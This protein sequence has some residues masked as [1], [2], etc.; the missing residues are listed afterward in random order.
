MH[1]LNWG[2]LPAEFCKECHFLHAALKNAKFHR[3]TERNTLWK[4]KIRTKN[5]TAGQ[6]ILYTY[7]VVVF[8][9]SIVSVY[10]SFLIL[11]WLNMVS[12]RSQHSKV[13]FANIFESFCG[14]FVVVCSHQKCV[15]FLGAHVLGNHMAEFTPFQ[16]KRGRSDIQHFRVYFTM[17]IVSLL[18]LI[19]TDRC[20]EI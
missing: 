8:L 4:W 11:N 9:T 13:A 3:N 5:S 19:V 6:Y 2:Y 20:M 1:C 17:K 10:M 18:I 15:F 7:N 12:L 16:N 14:G